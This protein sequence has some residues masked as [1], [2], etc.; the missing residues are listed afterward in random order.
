MKHMATQRTKAMKKLSKLRHLEDIYYK[1]N[2]L[3]KIRQKK[4]K[5]KDK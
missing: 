4:E 1:E 2:D 3:I 5:K